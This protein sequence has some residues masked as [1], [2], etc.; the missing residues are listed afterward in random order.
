MK[1]PGRKRTT[2]T[3]AFGTST[4]NQ[5]PAVT[6]LFPAAASLS[7]VRRLGS[8]SPAKRVDKENSR[9]GS[10]N[11]SSSRI[12]SPRATR[13]DTSLSALATASSRLDS[14]RSVRGTSGK[15]SA[16]KGAS[17][18]SE[19]PSTKSKQQAKVVTVATE[20][21]KPATGED[22]DASV[23]VVAS[24]SLPVE[25]SPDEVVEDLDVTLPHILTAEEEM[26]ELSVIGEEEEVGAPVLAP[27]TTL[28]EDDI[29]SAP[30]QTSVS[31]SASSPAEPTIPTPAIALA[32]K[33]IVVVVEE[34]DEVEEIEEKDLS[35][36]F[37]VPLND[38]PSRP[39]NTSSTRTPGNDS[40]RNVVTST[41]TGLGITRT[42]SSSP[43]TSIFSGAALPPTS[44]R[45][46]AST[47][48]V[49]STLFRPS[50]PSHGGGGKLNFGGLPSYR[51][52]EKSMGLSLNRAS[53]SGVSEASMTTQPSALPS[54][55]RKSVSGSDEPNKVLRRSDTDPM[56]EKAAP[57]PADAAKDRMG[58]LKS[59]LQS[60]KSGKVPL[61]PPSA[62]RSATA[63]QAASASMVLSSSALPRPS[64]FIPT[65]PTPAASSILAA[66]LPLPASPRAVR[67]PAAVTLKSPAPGPLTLHRS[68]SVN[69]LVKT[70]EKHLDTRI[71]SPTKGATT[72]SPTSAPGSPRRAA[73]PVA[74]ARPASP[75]PVPTP[76]RMVLR[77]PPRVYSPRP[78]V[79]S[80]L[81]AS[82]KASQMELAKP[83]EINASS[84][85]PQGSPSKP[86]TTV[87]SIL[88]ELDTAEEENEMDEDEEH[89]EIVAA[90]KE[91]VV[92]TLASK[93]SSPSIDRRSAEEKDRAEQDRLDAE[94]EANLPDLPSND[95]FA[96]DDAEE[97]VS[98]ATLVVEKGR[99]G[100]ASV[101]DVRT[102]R[103]EV[104]IRAVVNPVSPLRLTVPGAFHQELDESVE[105]KVRLTGL[106]FAGLN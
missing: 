79:P 29:D 47:A 92:K 12:L 60:L 43:P 77:S 64:P 1:T 53:V 34:A 7:A 73:L 10:S 49:P 32:E 39:A 40:L 11:G 68:S 9:P 38:D 93:V 13:S 41:T 26:V 55:K 48:T 61:S 31:P 17:L 103:E 72:F 18:T 106:S 75:L 99:G 35:E 76:S 78:A 66:P 90:V 71:P 42:G 91:K 87:A 56:E 3:S 96:H 51:E 20:V 82:V 58:L 25:A 5:D 37:D 23:S 84:T 89:V 88:Q 94:E 59:R 54:N 95:S 6:L 24:L 98:D 85:T 86:L 62:L 15:S 100:M 52:R 8:L 36:D 63:L 65:P 97:S 14:P 74:S 46:T 30:K 102:I 101:M 21:V 105:V 44:H 67:I 50:G 57:A 2:T 104:V 19:P 45:P 22:V 28:P 80:K 70:F 83:V 4:K 69:A 81:M 16:T 27:L 33:I